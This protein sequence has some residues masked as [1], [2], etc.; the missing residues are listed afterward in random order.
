M[1]AYD[2]SKGRAVKG[3]NVLNALYHNGEV[4]VPVA[5]EVIH[6]P[7]RFC[8]VTTRQVKRASVATQK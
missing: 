5:F 1:L 6:K 8:D 4:S 7:I 3:I 2:H